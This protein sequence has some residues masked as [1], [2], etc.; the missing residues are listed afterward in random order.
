MDVQGIMR[1][2]PHRFP[3][4]LVDRI[5]EMDVEQGTITGL[6]NVSV[7]EWF[8]QGHFPEQKVMP[9]VLLVESLAQTG[10]VLL[11]NM[12]DDIDNKLLVF[13]TIDSAKFR[14]PVVPGDQLKLDVTKTAQVGV[15]VRMKGKAT[16][17]GKVAAELVMSTAV[18]EKGK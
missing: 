4:L 3:F 6:K 13:M 5:L 17:E 9:G 14:R 11:M 16:V 7:N 8:F 18:V 15:Y 12:L 2:L 1:F 10:A